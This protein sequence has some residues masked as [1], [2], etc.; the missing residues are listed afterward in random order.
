M[1][2][3]SINEAALTEIQR[4]IR[5]SKCRDPIARLYETA[6]AERL[7]ENFKAA[8]Q[9]GTKGLQELEAMGKKR[10]EEVGDQL[11]FSLAVGAHERADYPPEYLTDISGI[12]FG[13]GAEICEALREYC[14]T[15]EDGRFLLRGPDNVAYTLRSLPRK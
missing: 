8:F 11:K 9:E 15:F 7:F 3:F 6:D 4:I 10:F 5:E 12:T 2:V 14:L 13:I 1:N